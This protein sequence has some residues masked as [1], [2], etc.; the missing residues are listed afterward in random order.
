MTNTTIHTASFLLT[1]AMA[2]ACQHAADS[3]GA[4]EAPGITRVMVVPAQDVLQV[5]ADEDAARREREQAQAELETAAARNDA[6]SRPLVTEADRAFLRDT[7]LD[8]QIEIALGETALQ[9]AERD[10]V[11]A[12]ARMMVDDHTAT[13]TQLAQLAGE[14]NVVLPADA[15]DR[16]AR[17]RADLAQ[18]DGPRFDRVYAERMVAAHVEAVEDVRRM[19]DSGTQPE[20]RSWAEA[21]LPRLEDHLQHAQ[22]LLSDIPTEP[23]ARR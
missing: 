5:A 13:T 10:D 22:K 4:T 18:W 6:P 8:A 3:D 19:A 7:M 1:L 20:L 11:K 16:L 15:N 9:Y 17:R 23:V 14:L 12:F 21:T 2:A